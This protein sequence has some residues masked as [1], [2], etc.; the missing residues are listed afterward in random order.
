MKLSYLV[1]CHNEGDSLEKC[2]VSLAL[3][4]DGDEVV[5]L[6][7]FSDNPRTLQVLSEWSSSVRVF[8][9]ALDKNYGAHKNFGNEQCIGD[10]VFQIDGDEIPSP[11]LVINIKA[12][13]EANPTTELMFVPRINDF[14][15]VTAE[16]AA[17]W[18][19]RLSPCPACDN[20][21]VVNWPDYQGRVYKRDPA[22]IR[23]DRRLHEKIEGHSGF[24]TLPADTDLALYHDKTIE[25]QLKTNIRYNEWFTQEEN[26][27]HDVFSQ[28]K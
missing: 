2:L 5:I 17:Q 14:I 6:D 20:R 19:W 21:L 24:V 1:T 18:G 10:W 4:D 11:S 23:W 7:D 22:R 12:I 9:H 16:H 13:I 15:G 3:R 27:G 25:T 8:K 26:Q 28:K